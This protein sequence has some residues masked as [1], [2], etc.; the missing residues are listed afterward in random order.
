MLGSISDTY[1]L[2]QGLGVRL[3]SILG[4]DTKTRTLY[5]VGRNRRVYVKRHLHEGKSVYGIT[6]QEWVRVRDG[7]SMIL[8]TEVPFMPVT[9]LDD[10]NKPSASL[11]ITDDK[12][13]SWGGEYVKSFTLSIVD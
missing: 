1:S 2:Y 4:Y 7:G 8:A 3:L 6:E 13:I 12:Q 11:T 5:G 10:T 9:W